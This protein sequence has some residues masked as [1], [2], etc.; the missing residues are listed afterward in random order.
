MSNIQL[1]SMHQLDNLCEDWLEHLVQTKLHY[2]DVQ[3][4]QT[5]MPLHQLQG[6]DIFLT[7]RTGGGKSSNMWTPLLACR[8]LGHKAVAICVIP[9]KVLMEN[10]VSTTLGNG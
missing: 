10:L 6:D 4:F 9:T 1:A 7:L 3:S 5:E 8:A 2:T